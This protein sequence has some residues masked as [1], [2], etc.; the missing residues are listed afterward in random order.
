[1]CLLNTETQTPFSV[2][3]RSAT[4]AT[5]PP[6][7]SSLSA[8]RAP[9]KLFVATRAPVWLLIPE[10]NSSIGSDKGSTIS[11]HSRPALCRAV[12]AISGFP[13]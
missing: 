3:F 1:M 2:I 7:L 12:N 9:F 6:F 13:I 5:I 11:N 4:M 8:V 10:R